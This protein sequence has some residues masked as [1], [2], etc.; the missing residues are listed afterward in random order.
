MSLDRTLRLHGGLIRQRSVLSRAERIAKLLDEGKFDKDKDSP[1]GLPKVRVY[2]SRAGTKTKK[3]E[4]KLA[5][6]AEAAAAAPAGA[7]GAAVPGKAAD[8]KTA[9]QAKGKAPEAKAAAQA[10]GTAPEAKPKADA[11]GKGKE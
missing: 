8:A 2:H 11:K 7:P 1:F 10:K 4:A 5:E 3:A 9:T 6:G